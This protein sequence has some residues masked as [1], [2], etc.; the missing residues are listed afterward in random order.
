MILK[1]KSCTR[2]TKH[3]HHSVIPTLYFTHE[4]LGRNLY[5]YIIILRKLTKKTIVLDFI[6]C[7]NCG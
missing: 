4:L 1:L 3:N 7:K 2:S 5:Y 6:F